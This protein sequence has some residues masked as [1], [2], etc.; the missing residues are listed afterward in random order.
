MEPELF[1]VKKEFGLTPFDQESIEIYSRIE[2][3]SSLRA[4]TWKERNVKFHRKLFRLAKKITDNNPNFTDPYFLIKAIQLDINSVDMFK[5]IR[6]D[7]MQT[8]KSLKFKKMGNV[9]FSKL[10]ID[11]R[12]MIEQNL[13]ILL[14]GVTQQRFRQIADEIYYEH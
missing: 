11:V 3:G 1:L 14:P 4:D 2:Y 12:N 7:V 13:N 9:Q 8:P 5:D 10:Y 6:G